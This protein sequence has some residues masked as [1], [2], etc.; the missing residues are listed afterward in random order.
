[1]L[2]HYAGPLAHLLL[3][4][5]QLYSVRCIWAPYK[6]S[7]SRDSVIASNCKQSYNT[8]GWLFPYH[9]MSKFTKP[10]P[11]SGIFMTI[12]LQSFAAESLPNSDGMDT[13]CW[14]FI[15]KIIELYSVSMVFHIVCWTKLM[16]NVSRVRSDLLRIK[17]LFNCQY[18][19]T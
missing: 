7:S 5:H 2:S 9:A 12:N 13:H 8:T 14:W 4:L 11:V 16:W 19:I 15:A 18:C 17:M 6:K 1:M 10:L 3:N